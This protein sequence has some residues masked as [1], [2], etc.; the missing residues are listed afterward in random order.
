MN[1]VITPKPTGEYAVGSF[2]FTI[3]N[4]REETIYCAKG[5]MRSLPVRVYYPAKKESVE[6]LNK[7]RY[8]SKEMVGIIRKKFMVPINYEKLE[9]EGSNRSECYDNAPFIEDKS[10]PLIIFN[11]GHGSFRDA[12]SFLCIELASHGYVIASI[13]HPYDAVLTELDDG[14]V[15]K[16]PKGIVS[17]CYSPTIP[18]IIAMKKMQKAK[19]T[20]EELWKKL[21]EMQKKH[22]RFIMERIDEWCIDTKSVLGYLKE[23][24]SNIIN[25]EKGVGLTGH[26]LGGATAYSLCEED[27]ETFTCGINIDGG[28]FGEHEG[29]DIN[30]PFLQ[31]N[32]VP[33]MTTVTVAFLR[34]KKPA[35]H[36]VFKDMQHL[37]FTDFKY[38]IP[39]KSQVGKLDPNVAHEENCKIHLEFFDAYLKKT[40]NR[41][42]LESDGTVTVTEY[43]PK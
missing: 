19:G 40:K 34:N 4:N 15:Y 37:G 12:N 33:D 26:S 3:Y 32:C 16:L 10:F 41:P 23:N 18:A 29:K 43:E 13:G 9:N 25:F 5:S 35:Y 6:G 39:L 17:K 36:V 20:N 11:H 30:A 22:N 8:M 31:I 27:P 38:V 7:T 2:T 1:N 14:T 21:D 42:M 24:Y 28:L